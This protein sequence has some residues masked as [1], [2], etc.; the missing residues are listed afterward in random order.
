MWK[1]KI[2]AYQ[3]L[4]FD[5]YIEDGTVIGHYMIDE[6]HDPTNWNG[7]LVSQA[8]LEEMA[9]YSKRY[10]PKMVTI[11]RTWP[12]YLSRWNGNYRH[13]DAAWAQ[14]SRRKGDASTFIANNVYHAKAK[15]LAL[16]VGLNIIDGDDG[17]PMSPSQVKSWGST[18]LSSPY[19]CAFLSWRY[20]DWYMKSS[21]I[22]S[23]MEQLRNLAENR[24]SKS[25]RPA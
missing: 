12:E 10:W 18:L 13:L 9:E 3:G 8:T 11:A 1:R 16:I 4:D 20:Y 23:A 24:S 17:D 6:P 25:C 15:G 7:K 22:R 2:D 19:P 21:G 14:Y 5:S